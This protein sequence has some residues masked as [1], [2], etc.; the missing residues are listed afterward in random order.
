[1]PLASLVSFSLKRLGRFF[2]LFFFLSNMLIVFIL[3]RPALTILRKMGSRR[4]D[5]LLEL[6]GK[7]KKKS[8]FFFFSNIACAF[9]AKSVG[10]L[11]SKYDC[12]NFE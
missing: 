2:F 10:K 3:N 5:A 7:E 1:M 6:K 12:L 8:T 4:S 9:F 11:L